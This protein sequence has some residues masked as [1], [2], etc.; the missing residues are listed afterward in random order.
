MYKYF[1]AAFDHLW[2]SI[3]TIQA[4]SIFCVSKQLS[5]GTC[6][7]SL[8]EITDVKFFHCSIGMGSVSFFENNTQGFNLSFHIPKLWKQMHNAAPRSIK[9]ALPHPWKATKLIS[10]N[11]YHSAQF[12]RKRRLWCFQQNYSLFPVL[13]VYKRTCDCGATFSECKQLVLSKQKLV[14]S[15]M[16]AI[17]SWFENVAP[18]SKVLLYTNKTGKM[19]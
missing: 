19:L 2:L 12:H 16:W 6:V 17:R 9:N 5:D 15:A 18:R 3:L 8:W 10:S 4:T 13:L 7:H 1:T 11:H 14:L